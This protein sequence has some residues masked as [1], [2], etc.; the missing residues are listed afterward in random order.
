MKQN[1]LSFALFI[2][3]TITEEKQQEPGAITVSVPGVLQNDAK[4]LKVLLNGTESSAGA[5]GLHILK[6]ILSEMYFKV[7]T[8]RK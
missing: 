6:N 2:Y 1:T 5:L 7:C 3:F 8:I 4:N